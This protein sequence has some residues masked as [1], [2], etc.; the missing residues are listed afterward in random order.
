MYHPYQKNSSYLRDAIFHTYKQKCV[1]CGNMMQQRNMHIDHVLPSNMQQYQ[2]A[3]IL[4][5]LEELDNQGF[6]IDSIEN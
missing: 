4:K 6:V 3:E 2:S 1:Y 5:Y